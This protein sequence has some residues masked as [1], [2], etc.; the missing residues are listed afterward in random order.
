[1][2]YEER[3]TLVAP[4][5]IDCGICELHTCTED[6]KLYEQLI[7]RGIPKDRIPC[8]GCR[9]IKG[10]CP[11]IPSTCATYLCIEEKHVQFCYECNEFPCVKLH[12]SA[13]RADVLPHNLKVYNLCTIQRK[14]VDKFVEVST[15]IKQTYYKGKMKVGS[16]PQVGE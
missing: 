1:M 7:S 8:S 11:V 5:G 15:V 14:G 16:G 12:P 4:C 10:N 9:Y 2:Q 6:S 13:D 3:T